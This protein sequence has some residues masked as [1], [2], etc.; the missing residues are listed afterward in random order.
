MDS[1][2]VGVESLNGVKNG[3]MINAVKEFLEKMW[4]VRLRK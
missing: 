1:A 2:V 4:H 3:R